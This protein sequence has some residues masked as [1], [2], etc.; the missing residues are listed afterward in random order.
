MDDP[1]PEP[2][3][4]PVR[5]VRIVNIDIPIGTLM[6]MSFR[7]FVALIP[8]AIV[9]LILYAIGRAIVSA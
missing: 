2:V 5:H 1:K 6:V 8:L 9:L 3:A 7:L 4:D